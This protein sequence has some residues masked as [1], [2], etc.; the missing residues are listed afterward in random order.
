[1]RIHRIR[2]F[3]ARP[4][5][6]PSPRRCCCCVL[7]CS[8]VCGRACE[9]A[10]VRACVRERGCMRA[11]CV[12]VCVRAHARV[13][14]CVP[15]NL[16]TVVTVLCMRRSR[17]A[18]ASLQVLQRSTEPLQR[19]YNMLPRRPAMSHLASVQRWCARCRPAARRRCYTSQTA[20][21][22]GRGSRRCATRCGARRRR[23]PRR[24]RVGRRAAQRRMRGR[25]DRCRRMRR[26][27]G[28]ARRSCAVRAKWS[29]LERIPRTQD[30]RA[31]C[32]RRLRR[33]RWLA[34]AGGTSA[35]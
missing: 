23:P 14:A 32:A 17:A 4:S 19:R 1:M 18:A 5:L 24:R 25:R 9:R 21:S 30:A 20:T 10:C 29:C 33:V 2:V 22:A 15:S 7:V 3:C 27:G 28:S 34:R 35:S 12:C 8:R 31:H 16:T 13:C 11:A 26:R 6:R